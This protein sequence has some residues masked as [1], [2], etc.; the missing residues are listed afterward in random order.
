MIASTLQWKMSLLD[1][2]DECNAMDEFLRKLSKVEMVEISIG[3]ES[4]MRYPNVMQ[5]TRRTVAK[6]DV[7]ERF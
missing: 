2:W 1:D 4:K 7:S 6:I 5:D 3:R